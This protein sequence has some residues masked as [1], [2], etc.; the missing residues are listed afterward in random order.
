MECFCQG[1]NKNC[2]YC[3]GAGYIREC[4]C[5][6]RNENCDYCKGTGYITENESIERYGVSAEESKEAEKVPHNQMR[7]DFIDESTKKKQYR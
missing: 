3:G 6:G 2:K 1:Q 5:N 7:F 4:L